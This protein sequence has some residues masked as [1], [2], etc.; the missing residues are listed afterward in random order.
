MSVG[1]SALNG[2]ATSVIHLAEDLAMSD[3]M[4]EGSDPWKAV[5]S[6]RYLRERFNEPRGV[7]YALSTALSGG[8]K[9]AQQQQAAGNKWLDE[10]E[11]YWIG[12]QDAEIRA[13]LPP[14]GAA[15]PK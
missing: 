10:V 2:I 11:Q 5:E 6:V 9:D 12:R 7:I 3:I 14:P 4:N 15:R 1:L 8:V 13:N